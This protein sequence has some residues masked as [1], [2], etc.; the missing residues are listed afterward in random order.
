MEE[1]LQ[2]IEAYKN[3]IN[4]TQI[5]NPQELEK[6]RIKYLGTKG[7]VKNLFGEMKAVPAERKKEFG[8]V[9]NEFKQTAES[10]YETC[11]ELTSNN[12]PT[13]ANELDLSLPG[14]NIPVGSRHPI[15]LVRKRVIDIFH[16]LGFAV[17][18]GPEIEDDW[19][20]FTALTCPRIIL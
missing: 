4:A 6:F 17:A 14:D 5:T 16:R 2:Q 1:L 20:N 15:S 13:I 3:E 10:K 12:Q 18:D 9:L 11:K 7:I 8:Q 19:H